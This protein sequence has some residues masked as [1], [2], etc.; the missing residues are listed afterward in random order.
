MKEKYD[1]IIYNWQM[2]FQVLDFK[3]NCFLKLLDDKYLPI[4]STYTKDGA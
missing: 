4:K 3:K 1:L 2:I